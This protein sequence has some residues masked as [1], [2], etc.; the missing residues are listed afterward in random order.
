MTE[1]KRCGNCRYWSRGGIGAG[2]GGGYCLRWNVPKHP[3]NRHHADDC[4]EPK[5]VPNSTVK[6]TKK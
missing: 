1:D 2:R 5:G 6:E 4:W 3:Q